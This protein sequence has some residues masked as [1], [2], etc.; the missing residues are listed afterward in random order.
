MKKLAGLYFI[1]VSAIFMIAFMLIVMGAHIIALILGIGAQTLEDFGLLNNI[2]GVYESI[3]YWFFT[4][5]A[6]A[7]FL[8]VLY[9]LNG[10]LFLRFNKV[11][12]EGFAKGMQIR[13][14]QC[15]NIVLS[16]IAHFVIFIVA[17]IRR[18]DADLYLIS[19]VIFLFMLLSYAIPYFTYTRCF[20]GIENELDKYVNPYMPVNTTFTGGFIYIGAKAAIIPKYMMIIPLNRIESVKPLKLFLNKVVCFRLSDGKS[21]HIITGHYREIASALNKDNSI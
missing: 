13:K 18:D 20:P 19:F 16:V 10:L 4:V 9:F 12:K 6:P 17:L 5:F 14:R 15:K 8:A 2:P 1:F 7:L 11:C 3:I 21:F